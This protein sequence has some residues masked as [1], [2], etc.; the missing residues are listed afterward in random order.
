MQWNVSTGLA[1][2][3]V[4]QYH[5]SQVIKSVNMIIYFSSYYQSLYKRSLLSNPKSPELKIN[6]AKNVRQG[7][8]WRGAS[9]ASVWH[10]CRHVQ[11]PH[12]NKMAATKPPYNQVVPRV[13]PC[14][15]YESL[16]HN[17]SSSPE[18]SAARRAMW[19]RHHQVLVTISPQQ[20]II[21]V[22][23]CT[24]LQG[25]ISSP[26]LSSDTGRLIPPASLRHW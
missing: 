1:K 12:L 25:V 21:Y 24:S 5:S 17:W 2:D 7:A 26:L 8:K 19:R 20:P 11:A 10:S 18:G 16:G 23:S 15:K 13:A 3:A 9:A 22:S 6:K 14:F 4:E